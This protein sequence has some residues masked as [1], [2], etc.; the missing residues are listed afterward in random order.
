MQI[1]MALDATNV[2]SVANEA[3]KGLDQNTHKVAS[4][5]VGST[6]LCRLSFSIGKTDKS[7]G[8][9]EHSAVPQMRSTRSSANTKPDNLV[10]SSSVDTSVIH[11]MLKVEPG[12][13]L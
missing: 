11:S 3:C 6:S 7:S 13:A 8:L 5:K 2:A 1:V 10:A 4:E 9:K 12:P